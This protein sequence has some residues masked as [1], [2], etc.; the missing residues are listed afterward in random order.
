[1]A[2][3]TAE[4]ISIGDEMTSGARLDTN[5]R[6]ISRRLGE[7]GID[8]R[9]HSTV[10]DSLE[11][12][13]SIFRTAAG[14]ADYVI[15]TGGLGP[16]RDDLTREAMAE[17]SGRPLEFR[18]EVYQHIESLFAK[19]KREIPERNRLQAMFP[20][21]SQEIFNPQGTAPG[22]D[23]TLYP[24]ATS[25]CR[26]F[27]LP[28][29]P[30][31]MRRMFDETVAPRILESR[32]AGRCIRHQVMKFFGVGESD[33]EQRLGELIARGRQPR[34]G[35][36]VSAATIS[37]RITATGDSDEECGSL[38]QATRAEILQRAGDLYFGDGEDFEQQHAI[39]RELKLRN[40]SLAIV[41]LG[42]A[43]PLGDWFAGLGETSSYRGGLSL[44]NRSELERLRMNG[45]SGKR[46]E[47][48]ALDE[49]NSANDEGNAAADEKADGWPGQQFKSDWLLVVDE[50]PQI[51]LHTEAGRPAAQVRFDVLGPNS[52]RYTRTTT[53][54]GHPSILQARIAK[55]AMHWFREVLAGTD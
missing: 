16:T 38:I 1:M 2:E 36:T 32:S 15:S 13:V 29:V 18:S 55:A 17:L 30:A 47:N 49:D 24:A 11:D 48:V 34:I 51:N 6:W 45:M 14:R 9:F 19:R 50:Y 3:A 33:M 21:G 54:G 42:F 4:V 25:A 43:A 12:N 39:D 20:A 44:A 37:L 46:H 26:I 40:E 27:A 8:V 31:E 23:L 5:S 35:I 52:Q 22:V 7:L 10:G 41:E 28:G 53:L